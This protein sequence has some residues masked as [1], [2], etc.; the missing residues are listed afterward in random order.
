MS[1]AID[2]ASVWV[3]RRKGFLFQIVFFLEILEI[4]EIPGGKAR[5]V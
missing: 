1:V 4:L 5:R 2:G 3:Q